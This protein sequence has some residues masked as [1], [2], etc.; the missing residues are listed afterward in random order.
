MHSSAGMKK[1][2]SIQFLP[3]LVV[4]T[5]CCCRQAWLLT[6][7]GKHCLQFYY[8]LLQILPPV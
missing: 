7:K 8:V 6:Q 1:I 2:S 3:E 5:S 4:T